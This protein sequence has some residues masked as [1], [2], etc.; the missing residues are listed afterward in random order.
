METNGIETGILLRFICMNLNNEEKNKI[1]QTI[2]QNKTY[3]HRCNKFYTRVFTNE[4]E[5]SQIGSQYIH[6]SLVQTRAYF[7]TVPLSF[8]LIRRLSRKEKIGT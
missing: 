1:L 8:P 2:Q 6:V 5:N 4:K 7:T 3:I